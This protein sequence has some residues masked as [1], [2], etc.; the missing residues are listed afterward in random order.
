MP[1]SIA[2]V[3]ALPSISSLD[4]ASVIGGDNQPAATTQNQ[5]T[6]VQ[7]NLTCPAGTSPHWE[8]T[9]GQGAGSANGGLWGGSAQGGVNSQKFWCDPIPQT[10]T[11]PATTT[12]P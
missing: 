3:S 5:T 2:T 4:L 10:T 7:P 9:T 6:T 11:T 12:N 8:S 1:K